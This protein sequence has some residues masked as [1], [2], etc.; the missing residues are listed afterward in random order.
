MSFIYSR[1]SQ[2][3]THFDRKCVFCFLLKI[4]LFQG[5]YG[6]RSS[7]PVKFMVPHFLLKKYTS[8]INIL[9]VG[10]IKERH[11]VKACS[12]GGFSNGVF[13]AVD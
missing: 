7:A 9:I 5:I 4:P 6:K 1:F 3:N 10:F 8:G 13:A 2:R 11:V 12:V